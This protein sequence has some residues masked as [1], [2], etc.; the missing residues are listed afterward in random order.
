MFVNAAM[1]AVVGFEKGY[2][3]SGYAAAL[4]LGFVN[5]MFAVIFFGVFSM[6]LKWFS[7]HSSDSPF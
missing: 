3:A 7:P 1:N 2:G 4:P 6:G 5:G